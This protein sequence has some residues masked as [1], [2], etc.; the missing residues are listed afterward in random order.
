[1]NKVTITVVKEDG[2]AFVK[3]KAEF[4]LELIRTIKDWIEGDIGDYPY[5]EAEITTHRN[6][7][8]PYVEADWRKSDG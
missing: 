5:Q 1:M 8:K 6:T 7:T 3:S 2:A 4:N